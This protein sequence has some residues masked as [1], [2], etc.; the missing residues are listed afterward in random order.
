MS[1]LE[2]AGVAPGELRLVVFSGS[3]RDYIPSWSVSNEIMRLCGASDECLGLDMTAGCLATLAALDLIQ[4]WLSVRGGGHAAVIAAERWSQ[5][6]DYTDPSTVNLW[7]YGDSAGAIVVGLD[8]ARAGLLHYLG[9]EYRSASANNGHV[10]VPFG[11]TRA[12]QA[13]PGVNPHMRR[14]SDR[15][16]N[17]VTESY[18]K[19]YRGAFRALQDR[20]HLEPDRFICNQMSPQIVGMLTELFDMEGRVVVTGHETG[21]LGGPDVIVGLDT[22]LQKDHPDETVLMGASA[23]YG[24]GTG[25]LVPAG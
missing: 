20:F 21:H 18:R 17:E 8:V 3:S 6:I 22:Y 19:G 2:K 4:G 11:G 5:T 12:P 7:A 14:V 23:A 16:K 15:P 9:A 24:F 10:F 25:F 13:P 1:G